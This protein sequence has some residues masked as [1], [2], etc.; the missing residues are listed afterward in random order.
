V[1]PINSVICIKP[2][3]DGRYWDKLY[4]D[5][6]T[7][8]LHR[9]GIPIV[10]NPIDK[11]AIEEALKIR[12][13]RGGKVTV[14]SMGPPNT[15][16]ILAWAYALGVDNAVLVTDRVFGGADTWATAYALA[17]G[18]KKLGQVDL[19]MFGNESLDGST[20][21]VGPQVGEFLDIP[22]ITR[23][24]EIKFVNDDTIQVKSNIEM[25]FM[26]FE[27]KLPAVVTVTAE[28]NTVHI[29][30]VWGAIWA[31][32]KK[33]QILTNNEIGA[34][35]T[36]IGSAGSPTVVAKIDNIDT[37]RKSEVLTGTPSE[38]AQKLVQKLT[39]DGVLPE[40]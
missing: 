3:P 10:I 4:L 21:Q 29:P 16:D 22:S 26:R 19:V 38:I 34:D 30:T 20:G 40:K 37:K 9:E 13:Q 17:A 27:V 7:K 18:I 28:I 11:N 36:K 12:E 32:E 31:T 15:T 6:T 2:V 39:A 33:T 1:R 5:P 25:G 14:I 24:S 8:A 35:K 23:A